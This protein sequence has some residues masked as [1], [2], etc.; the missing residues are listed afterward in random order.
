MIIWNIKLVA[1][2]KG[3]TMKNLAEAAGISYSELYKIERGEADPRF[4]HVWGLAKAL[5]ADIT[6][7]FSENV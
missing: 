2:E 7:L 5:Q 6:D 1:Q 4:S 3:L